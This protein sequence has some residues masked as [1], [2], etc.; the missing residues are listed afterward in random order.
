M[1]AREG[2]SRAW[3]TRPQ[4]AVLAVAVWLGL[5]TVWAFVLH[6]HLFH[7]W[8]SSTHRFGD[9]FQRL[10]ET[11]L[12]LNGHDPYFVGRHISDNVPPAVSLLHVPLTWVSPHDVGFVACWLSLASVGVI[13]AAAAST[14]LSCRRSTA[15][16]VA[17]FAALPICAITVFPVTAAL[18]TGQDQLWFMA[19]VAVDLLW[20]PPRRSGLLV[21]L[22]ASLSLWPAIFLLAI[23][24]RSSL[25]GVLRA[26][27]GGAVGLVAGAIFAPWASWHYWTYL[28]PSGQVSSR[29]VN[30]S[31]PWPVSGF[32]GTWNISINGILSRPPLGGSFA[33]RPVFLVAFVVVLALTIAAAWGLWRLGLTLCPL[34]ILSLGAV[35]ASPFAWQHHWVWVALW[36][37]FAGIEAFRAG[38]RVL[39]TI[40]GLSTLVF[41]RQ[42]YNHIGA[43]VTRSHG[44]VV[45]TSASGFLFINAYQ[46]TGLFLLATS[47]VVLG[48]TRHRATRTPSPA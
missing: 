38:H 3:A 44:H 26:L 4:R 37:P 15:L 17:S 27:L 23:A 1:T 43:Y 12:L 19:L 10:V 36:V 11:R 35:E 18:S 25:R 6:R 31:A 5:T 21:G 24:A 32:K 7:G 28:V 22:V 48:L 45:L 33:T 14:A 42:G 29:G 20:V 47:V 39:G 16:V 46:L 8:V 2:T 40:F 30:S 13:T 41:F 9:L 34:V